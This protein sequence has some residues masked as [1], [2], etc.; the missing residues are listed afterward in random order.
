MIT[1][2]SGNALKQGD[3][4]PVCFEALFRFHESV[5]NLFAKIVQLKTSLVDF[6]TD[7]LMDVE[8]IIFRATFETFLAVESLCD[9]AWAGE[10]AAHVDDSLNGIG[11]AFLALAD[12]S[13]LCPL[14]VLADCR[15]SH[16]SIY[17]NF[18]NNYSHLND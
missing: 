4:L 17:L 9:E 3:D 15:L 10:I 12:G 7:L 2:K 5:L 13:V 6:L 16:H 14:I 8:V 18:N 11:F 1:F